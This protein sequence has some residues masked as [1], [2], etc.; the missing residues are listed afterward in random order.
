MSCTNGQSAPRSPSGRPLKLTLRPANPSDAVP[1]GFFFDT[2]LRRDYFLR[3][4]QLVDMLSSRY[5]QVLVAELDS[6]L[7]GVA[8][9]TRGTR[10]VNA[11]VHPNYRGL[12]IGAALVGYSGAT[13]VRAKIDSSGGDP[14]PFYKRLGFAVTGERNAKGNVEIMRRDGAARRT[15]AAGANGQKAR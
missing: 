6:I 14:R 15:G 3:R 12:G 2:A 9:T 8:I 5:H 1:L 13:E 7:V 10:L 11:L 4:G